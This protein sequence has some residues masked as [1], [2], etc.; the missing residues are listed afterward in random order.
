MSYTMRSSPVVVNQIE[1]PVITGFSRPNPATKTVWRKTTL[2]PKQRTQ[3][4]AAV[5]Q[6]P[7]VLRIGT[8]YQ[9]QRVALSSLRGDLAA[10]INA[11]GVNHAFYD[12]ASRNRL[13]NPDSSDA[14]NP[15]P[16]L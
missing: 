14:L 16:T 12:P 9:V 5:A 15:P 11:T 4:Q 3:P 1:R 13:K 2:S 7:A 8:D 10:P 6:T